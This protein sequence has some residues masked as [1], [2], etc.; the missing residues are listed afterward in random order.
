MTTPDDPRP[1]AGPSARPAAVDRY[2]EVVAG[3]ASAVGDLRERDAERAE[4]LR[5]RL[6]STERDLHGAADGLT[7]AR[8]MFELRWE[9]ALQVLWSA[10]EPGKPRPRAD[11]RA[12][13]ARHEQLEREADEALDGLRESGTR[14][15]FRL[16][17][18]GN[19]D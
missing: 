6:R 9:A 12:D 10:E 11:H 15:L 2:R 13:P 5:R 3:L 14:R 19:G 7:L 1:A 8:G 4:E 18:R 16:P 17:R